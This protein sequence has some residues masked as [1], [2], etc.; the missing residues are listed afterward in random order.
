MSRWLKQW[1]DE[2]NLEIFD[3]PFYYKWWSMIKM[4]AT[5]VPKYTK[6][7]GTKSRIRITYG[8]WAVTISSLR[9]QMNNCDDGAVLTF[10]QTLIDEGLIALRKSGQ[11][12]VIT[13]LNFE[14]YYSNMPPGGEPDFDPSRYENKVDIAPQTISQLLNEPLYEKAGQPLNRI[15]NKTASQSHS[16]TL[17]ETSSEPPCPII[18][19]EDRRKRKKSEI[20]NK[21]RE[22]EFFKEL[23]SSDLMLEEIRRGLKVEKEFFDELLEDFHLY[24]IITNQSHAD[25]SKFREHFFNWSRQ[26]IEKFSK[27]Q[28][29]TN[30]GPQSKTKSPTG[31]RAAER[32]GFEGTAK[33]VEDYS[34]PLPN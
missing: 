19:E 22:E 12:L 5:I 23:K 28:N 4:N 2:V 7:G 11:G 32:R 13:I 30:Y 24:V 34:K 10:L 18:I 16:Q 21:A 20:E 8:E 29:K 31:S 25:F 9:R 14:R 33:S 26:Q 1:D 6:A 17:N 3:H 27:N 15:Q